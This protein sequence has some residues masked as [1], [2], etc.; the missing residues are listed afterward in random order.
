MIWRRGDP[1]WSPVDGMWTNHRRGIV[2][3]I[4]NRVGRQNLRRGTMH[5]APT[6]ENVNH[7]FN[8]EVQHLG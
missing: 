7:E 2:S 4:G 8:K 3:Q 1:M 6:K 5:R